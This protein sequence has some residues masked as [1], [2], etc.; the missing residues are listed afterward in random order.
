ARRSGGLPQGNSAPPR[1]RRADQEDQQQEGGP[2][3]GHASAGE[4]DED[5]PR[6]HDSSD[7]SN[8]AVAAPITTA[9]SL[10]SLTARTMRAVADGMKPPAVDRG[11]PT[12][13]GAG[14]PRASPDGP[15]RRSRTG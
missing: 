6:V 9:K 7:Q 11:C 13:C 1:R 4:P 3:P 10:Q 14:R 8:D 12:P 5:E 2:A 15:L